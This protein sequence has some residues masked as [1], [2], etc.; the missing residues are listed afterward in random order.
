MGKYDNYNNAKRIKKARRKLNRRTRCLFKSQ[1]RI[2]KAQAELDTAKL[3][4]SCQI[5]KAW[6][7]YAPNENIMFSDDNRV[8]WF[9]SHVIPYDDIVACRI[10]ENLIT[11]SHTVTTPRGVIPRAI[12]G[13]ALAGDIG[14][15][16]G[17]MTA[18]S[19]SETTYYQQGDGFTF[20]IFT[21]DGL[22]HSCELPNFSGFSFS[23][24][25]HPKWVE[26]GDKIQRIIDGIN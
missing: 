25:I 23:N 13:H 15:V 5:F 9:I 4:E 8:M 22:R 1:T 20:Q 11:K 2:A 14:A 26:V 7:S 10:G 21:K 3:F 18:K 12:A 17:A 24:K 6:H 19:T 16:V